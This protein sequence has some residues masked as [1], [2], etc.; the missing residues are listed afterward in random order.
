[1]I[2]S[3]AAAAFLLTKKFREE[4]VGRAAEI[5]LFSV[6]L[7]SFLFITLFKAVTPR[8][9][10][11]DFLLSL[12]FILSIIASSAAA[13]LLLKMTLPKE[14]YASSLPLIMMPNVFLFPLLF[15]HSEMGSSYS[16]LNAFAMLSVFFV[17]AGI[18]LSLIYGR[19]LPAGSFPPTRISFLFLFPLAGFILALISANEFLPWFI[20]VQFET[21]GMMALPLALLY[22][23]FSLLKS[24]GSLKS[25]DFQTV[26][27]FILLKH[28]LIP[29]L[30][31]TVIYVFNIEYRFAV[32]MMLLASSP[33]SPSVAFGKDDS[34]SKQILFYSTLAS[35]LF[36]PVSFFLLGRIY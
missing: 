8:E 29:L 18:I 23:G 27:I 31:F 6:S 17:P 4:S 36:A 26:G 13:G 33:A 34:L 14:K 22:V 19:F 15:L 20:T 16:I 24:A 2:L 10:I 1:M 30:T 12:V 21:I 35:A 11:A 9:G 28:I 3:G 32:P 5:L 7:P 25:A